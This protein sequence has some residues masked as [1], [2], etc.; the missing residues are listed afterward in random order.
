MYH[1]A[2]FNQDIGKW[3]VSNVTTMSWMFYNATKFSRDIGEWDV[4][5]VTTMYSMFTDAECST[6]RPQLVN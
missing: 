6:T 4:S 5:K 2:A 3:D 1:A